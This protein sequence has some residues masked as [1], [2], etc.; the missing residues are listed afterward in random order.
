MSNNNKKK[1]LDFATKLFYEK[2]YNDTTF[3]T[4]AEHCEIT[5][6]LITYYFATKSNLASEIIHKYTSEIKNYITEK[7][8]N[9][10]DN[11]NLQYGTAVEIMTLLQL[12][13]DDQKALRFFCEYMNSGFESH[14]PKNIENILSFYKMHD[15]HYHLNIDHSADELTMLTTVS[16]FSINSLNYAYFT[17]KLNC[18]YEQFCD[19]TVRIPFKFMNIKEEQIDIIIKEAKNILEQLNIKILPYFK[20]I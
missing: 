15:R 5:K 19:Y 12:Y 7:I 4:I 17:G 9:N 20:V 6:P 8:S 1:I 3:E 10:Y 14:F 11:Y 2:G 13:K 16:T 18:T